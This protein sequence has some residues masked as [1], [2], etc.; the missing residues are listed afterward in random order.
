MDSNKLQMNLTVEYWHNLQ[1]RTA[2]FVL[3][4]TILEQNPAAIA[5]EPVITTTVFS[6]R[7]AAAR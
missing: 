4:V 3:H 6:S 7:L 5:C 2:P 1:G